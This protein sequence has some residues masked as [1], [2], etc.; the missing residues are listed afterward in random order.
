MRKYLF[1]DRLV[2][3][4]S[5]S[6]SHSLSVCCCFSIF[7]C[8]SS[9]EK[10]QAP[11]HNM[12][13]ISSFFFFFTRLNKNDWWNINRISERFFSS[14]SL[15][16]CFSCL[17][18][19]NRNHPIITTVRVKCIG[20]KENKE[21]Q[22]AREMSNGAFSTSHPVTTTTA[23]F[24]RSDQEEKLRTKGKKQ[25]TTKKKEWRYESKNIDLSDW[26]NR[27]RKPRSSTSFNWYCQSIEMVRNRQQEAE[28]G[29]C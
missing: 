28:W 16:S 3:H 4:L 15:F 19:K 17:T 14:L 20:W 26:I 8:Q 23:R 27:K 2:T 7:S 25:T 11:S 5:P 22:E 10:Q 29:H 13:L 12:S 6:L 9:K 18:Q 1:I 21:E 24:L